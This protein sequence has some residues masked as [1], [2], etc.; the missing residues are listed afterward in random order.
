MH[1]VNT[2]QPN[3]NLRALNMTEALLSARYSGTE[4]QLF[5]QHLM[6]VVNDCTYSTLNSQPVRVAYRVFQMQQ[7][8]WQVVKHMGHVLQ[9]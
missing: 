2:A 3:S 6:G 4:T 1:V 9:I 8:D 7:M 5:P